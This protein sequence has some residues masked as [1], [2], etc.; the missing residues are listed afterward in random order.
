MVHILQNKAFDTHKQLLLEVQ[1]DTQTVVSPHGLVGSKYPA[2]V[3]AEITEALQHA[4]LMNGVR[5]S[6]QQRY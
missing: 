5:R 1:A 6:V 4:K 3:E 2:A